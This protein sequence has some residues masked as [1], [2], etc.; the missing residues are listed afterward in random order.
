MAGLGTLLLLTGCVG[1]QARLAALNKPHPGTAAAAIPGPRNACPRTSPLPAGQAVLVEWV[2]FV[3][4]RGVMFVFGS[5]PKVSATPHDLGPVVAHV[6][7]TFAE[8]TGDGKHAA[9]TPADGD[10]AFIPAGSP[11]YAVRGFAAACR[12]AARVDGQI[13]VYLAQRTVEGH[14]A[15]KPCAVSATHQR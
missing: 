12:V 9:P 3:D 10:A 11:V 1:A 2:D 15:P 13:R 5:P 7:C 6:R 14:S 8:L 4:I